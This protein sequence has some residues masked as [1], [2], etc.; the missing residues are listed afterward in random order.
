MKQVNTATV[1]TYQVI[2]IGQI[3]L[4]ESNYLT[5]WGHVQQADGW[6]RCDFVTTYDV[7]NTMIRFVKDRSDAVQMTI[8]KKLEDMSQIPEIID[9][10]AELG[11][12]V[13]FDDM[14]FKLTR[15]GFREHGH[16]IEYTE[17]E[18]WYIEQV[19]PQPLVKTRKYEKKVDQCMDVLYMSYELY[20]G[21]LELDFDEESARI[22]ADLADD[23][24]YKLAYYAWKERAI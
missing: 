2:S 19:I 4:D 18:C 5:F 3:I 13:V 22:K 6:H 21:Y 17:G 24:K 12:P 1:H 9:L 11:A 8:V 16:W 7:L 14:E 10:E 20:M 15:P 23:L